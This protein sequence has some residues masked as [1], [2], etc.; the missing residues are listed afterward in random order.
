MRAFWAGVVPGAPGGAPYYAPITNTINAAWQQSE[1]TAGFGYTAVALSD[2][3]VIKKITVWVNNA[4]SGGSSWILTL[5]QNLANS[6][7]VV[8]VDG[9]NT[10]ASWQG[11]L[12]VA[13]LD[14][15][16]MQVSWTGSPGSPGIIYW[17]IEYE[18][19]GN[20]YMIPST[21]AGNQNF[22][23][24]PNP[25]GSNTPWTSTATD[26]EVVVPTALTVT[27]IAGSLVA[28][29][30]AGSGFLWNVRKN[31][32][33]D[34][35]FQASVSGGSA[36]KAVSSTGALAFAAGDTMVIKFASSGNP[37]WYNPQQC[38]T[39]EPAIP[40]EIIACFGNTGSPSASST[41]YNSPQ[42][43][44]ATAGWDATEGNV[45]M[46][47]PAGQL[48]KIY[49]KMGTASGG[50]RS[51]TFT[52]RS[53][54]ADTSVAVVVGNTATG[55]NTSAVANHGDGNLLVIKHTPSGTPNTATGGIHLGLVLVIPQPYRNIG[56]KQSVQASLR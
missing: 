27:K 50:G 7:A 33:T 13:Q 42:G 26:W 14:Q 10:F 44:G 8:T 32:T 20:F 39:V 51:R 48:K 2:A 5:R 40:G 19:A 41:D 12:P 55:N 3:C 25:F 31:N 35:S 46:R 18:T 16:S 53:N 15:L 30:G 29:P 22:T 11:N 38:I 4:P 17:V 24:Y 36:T 49:V 37:G 54:N 28:A 52:A 34:S 45:A 1:N 6:A 23:N 47:F 9:T 21:A 56:P 43:Y